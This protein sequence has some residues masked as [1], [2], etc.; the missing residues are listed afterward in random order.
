MLDWSKRGQLAVALAGS[1]YLLNTQG[2]GINQL[3]NMETDSIYVSSLQWNKSGKY[4]AV[5][6]SDAEVQ[7]CELSLSQDIISY[8]T[9]MK[10]WFHQ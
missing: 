9:V 7:V 4:L 8:T 10:S 3:C 6:T 2:G 5:G 1:V